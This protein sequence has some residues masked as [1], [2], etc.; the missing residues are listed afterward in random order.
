MSGLLGYGAWY[1]ATHNAELL[2]RLG[3]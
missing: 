2:V 1:E 3:T